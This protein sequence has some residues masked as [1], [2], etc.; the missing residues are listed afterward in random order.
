MEQEHPALDAL[1]DIKQ[2]MERSSRFI[3]LS[4]LSGVAA[5]ICALTGAWF[6]YQVISGN[7]PVYKESYDYGSLTLGNIMKYKLP[8]IALLTLGSAILTAFLFT[9]IKSKKSNTPIWGTTSKR[10]ILNFCIPLFAGGVFLLRMTELGYFEMIA[11]GCL[12]FYGIALVNA[13][14]YTLG[15]VR[16]LGYGQIVLGLIGCWFPALG[17]FFW[18]LGFGALHILY[19]SLMWWKYDKKR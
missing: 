13:G 19:G 2:M 9:Y 7:N 3:S 12:L 15:E 1:K 14:K 17:L 4:G 16:Y 6:A 5:G 10:L 8:A 11:P 18:T